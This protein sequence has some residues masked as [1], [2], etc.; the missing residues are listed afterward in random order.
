MELQVLDIDY[1]S[2]DVSGRPVIRIFGG[3]MT[4]R[5]DVI[6][7]RGFEPY[8]YARVE[9]EL[10]DQL[11]DIIEQMDGVGRV[12]VVE[13]FRPI[14]YQSKKTPML[15]IVTVSPKNVRA[16]RE[17]VQKNDGVLEVY[18]ADI[19]FHSRFS[20]D[21]NVTGMS[22]V[23]ADDIE[24]WRDGIYRIEREENIPLRILSFD[25]EVL[26]PADGSFPDAEKDEIIFLSMAFSEPF[27]GVKNLVVMA[28]GIECPRP[29]VITVRNERAL[30]YEFINIVKEFDPDVITGYNIA[31]FDAPYIQKRMEKH[32]MRC[33]I[34]RD[35][36]EW[37]IR[38]IGDRNEIRV[39]GRVSIDTLMM[40]RK[41]YSL[42]QYNLKTVARELL[43]MEKLDVPASRMR[44][45]WFG[46]EEQFAEFVKYSRRDAV[47]AL[48]LI[49]D[50]GMLDKY[51]AL[52]RTTG[53]LLQDVINGGQSAM[54]EFML[55]Q[56]YNRAER[57]MGMK[58]E[59]SGEDD[60]V[61]YQ[62]AYVSEP[63]I[64]VHDHLILTDMQSLYPSI[65][66]SN[67]LCP[68]TVIIEED[69][70]RTH[71]AP[72]GGRFVDKEVLEG[73]LPQMLNEVLQKR[74]A[75]KKKMKQADG[76]ERDVLDAIQYSLKIVINSA[77]GWMG[78]KRSRL[79]NITTASA[80]TAY[81]REVIGEVRRRFEEFRDIE[82]N[83]KL[84][85]FHVVY[86][87]TDSAYVKL[88]CNDEISIEDADAIGEKVAAMITEPMPPPMKL[89][90]EGYAR[91]A[92]FLAKKRYAM[93]LQERAKDG[94]IKEKLKV[95]GIE[96]VRRD[97]CPLTGK[98]M[99][100]CLEMILRD[101]DVEG[102]QRHAREVIERVREFRISSGD[103]V[104][105]EDLALTRNYNKK[106]SEFKAKP[107]H[108][109]MIE[110]MEK[111]GEPLPG[112]GDRISFYIMS[113]WESFADRAET[114]D[115]I[116]RAGR[117]IDSDYYVEKQLV[118]PLSRLFGALGVQID[119]K[120]G[121]K[122]ARELDLTSFL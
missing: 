27:R 52:S 34:G 5:R 111:R 64:G 90:Y 122:S 121:E 78:Y 57:V 46:T 38:A 32:G 49:T 88:I 31:G 119:G 14:G 63:E 70:E 109:R 13:R 54:L 8:F 69:C 118:P 10:V 102:A 55:L 30:L 15:K 48:K 89:N 3:D 28:K 16:L 72:N 20:A 73:I 41:N 44:E 87:D 19:L 23:Y 26:T 110:R 96:M 39:A 104:M 4:G 82:A 59:V 11:R 116:R 60:G 40:V 113:G 97:W 76:R 24:V 9:P 33:V 6:E 36:S 74:I 53:L 80:V 93:L 35:W 84:F 91:R 29:D 107:A 7:V 66:I 68:T 67:N 79:F 22:W 51:I 100:R 81:G 45:F 112:L 71:T 94:T 21:S 75:I 43:K 99:K 86:T 50:L 58:P 115:Y 18:E 17:E 85:N 105:L 62:G 2:D 47:L 98:T 1:Y 117:E 56:R 114:L 95:R 42:S 65:V 12:E 83:G 61:E 37:E 25:I 77:Y 103:Q 92:L 101:G 120:T 108:I 106:A